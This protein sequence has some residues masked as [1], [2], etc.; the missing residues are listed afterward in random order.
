MTRPT[1][2]GN[3]SARDEKT[4]ARVAPCG[5][6]Q[7]YRLGLSQQ[8]SHTEQ[9]DG[10]GDD[11]GTRSNRG[12]VVAQRRGGLV[13][14]GVFMLRKLKPSGSSGGFHLREFREFALLGTAK[15]AAARRGQ[16][17]RARAVRRCAGKQHVKVESA[18]AKTARPHRSPR[19]ATG[20]A[21][22]MQIE[23]RRIAGGDETNFLGWRLSGRGKF[24]SP[25]L[26]KPPGRA[27]ARPAKAAAL[28]R[29]QP[30]RRFRQTYFFEMPNDMRDERLAIE[31]QQRFGPAH[32]R[33]LA[34]R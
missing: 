32:A 4:C 29:V 18:L 31:R 19:F 24:R 1:R 3:L 12:L 7:R 30:R 11:G 9:L 34:A 26:D 2:T 20:D 33:T 23:K 5:S 8:A 25:D 17:V 6:D 28:V 27:P 22:S 13:V 21:R 15:S 14:R 10:N 16:A